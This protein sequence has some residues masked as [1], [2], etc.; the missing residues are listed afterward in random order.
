MKM[1]TFEAESMH[2]ALSKVKQ[3][4]GEDAVIVKNRKISR[5]SG[6]KLVDLFEVTAALEEDLAHPMAIPASISKAAVTANGPS[7]RAPIATRRDSIP[8]SEGKAAPALPSPL[9]DWTGSKPAYDWKGSLPRVQ[10]QAKPTVEAPSAQAPVKAGEQAQNKFMDLLRNEFRDV[11][12]RV[13]MPTRELRIL[14]DEIRQALAG[15]SSREPFFSEGMGA[16]S[17]MHEHL[18]Q[19]GFERGEARRILIAVL[20]QMPVEPSIAEMVQAIRKM[21]AQEVRCTGGV[22]FARGR[23]TRIAVVGPGG[24]GKTTTLLKL[25]TIAALRSGKRVGILSGDSM[26]LGAHAQLEVFGKTSGMP[27]FPVYDPSDLNAVAPHAENLDLLLLDTAGRAPVK[28]DVE[29]D[30]QMQLVQAF[31]PDETLLVLSAT[32]RC[33]ELENQCRRFQAYRPA[34]LALTRLDECMELGT[35]QALTRHTGLPLSYLCDGPSVPEHIQTAKPHH[36]AHLLLPESKGIR[37][38]VPGR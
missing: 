27:V 18:L 13:E 35:V 36:L 10:E 5:R 8:S 21:I 4:M 1:R 2:E 28:G 30:R 6:G 16:A 31:S 17:Q 14:T 7:P 25:A 11:K 26:R 20:S 33:R 23:A 12:E 15:A 34:S 24:A 29:A 9:P 32:T 38:L 3:E 19:C 22:R 37:S